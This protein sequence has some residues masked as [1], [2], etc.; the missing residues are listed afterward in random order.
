MLRQIINS[1][2]SLSSGANG[3]RTINLIR[4]KLPKLEHFSDQELQQESLTLQFAA[5]SG[6]PT[7]ALLPDAFALASEASR[8]VHSM[9]P[10]DVQ[11]LGGMNLCGHT[12]VEMATG[13]GKTLTALL[14][15]YLRAIEGKGV[16]LARRRPPQ[17]VRL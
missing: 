8:R 17:S 3:K 15:L 5:R 10:Y 9:V 7:R 4:S 1:L 14:P 13:E 6:K 11:F 12:I 2:T 16:L